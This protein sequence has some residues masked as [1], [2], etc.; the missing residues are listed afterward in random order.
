MKSQAEPSQD[1]RPTRTEAT[2]QALMDAA[3][4]LIAEKGVENVSIRE[5]LRASGQ[6]NESALHYHF[7]NLSGLITT[8]RHRRDKEVHEKRTALIEQTLSR[9]PAPTLRELCELMVGPAFQLA[10]S[11]TGFRRYIKAFGHELTLADAP[12]SRLT[13]RINGE[14]NQRLGHYLRDALDHLDEVA[15]QRRMDSALRFISASMVHE[16]RQKNAFRGH[17]ANVFYSS[18]IDTLVGLLSAPE[19]PETTAIRRQAGD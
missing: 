4:K 7:K 18:L 16:A 9:S 12:A 13:N 10:Q 5:I 6:K 1:S 2:R 8:L 11:S 15:Y 19:S 14:S 3:E 17:A